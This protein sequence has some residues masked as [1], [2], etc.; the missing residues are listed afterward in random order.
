MADTRQ[1]PS[2]FTQAEVAEIIREATSHMLSA[3][4]DRQLTREELLAMARELG[5]SEEAVE[6]VLAAR[7]QKSRTG[8]TPTLSRGARIGLAAHGMSYGIVISGLSIVDIMTG[9]GWWVQWPALGWGMG[10]AF[11][12]MGLFLAQ[13][14]RTESK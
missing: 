5:V 9:P 8:K 10:L 7:A 1:H 13:M 4:G 12:C 2:R 6:Q 14:K 3:Q 11:H